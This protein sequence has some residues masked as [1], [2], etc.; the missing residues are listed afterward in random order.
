MKKRKYLNWYIQDKINK[1]NND[2]IEKILL[3][4]DNLYNKLRTLLEQ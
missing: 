2:E 4:M 1:N 3:K